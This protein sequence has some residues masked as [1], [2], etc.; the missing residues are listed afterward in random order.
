MLAEAGVTKREGLLP[1]PQFNSKALA[2]KPEIA[3]NILML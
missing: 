2:S 1:L 3:S